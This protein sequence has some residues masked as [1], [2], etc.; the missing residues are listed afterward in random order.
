MTAGQE[1]RRVHS[2]MYDVGCWAIKA[3]YFCSKLLLFIAAD[4]S[5]FAVEQQL[6]V[7]PI[8]AKLY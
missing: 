4:W 2:C 7:I 5:N 1:K 3:R 6:G 8:V